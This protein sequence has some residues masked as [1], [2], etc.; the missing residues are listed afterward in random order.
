M[1]GGVDSSVSAYLLKKQGYEV[2]ALF[3]SDNPTL[4]TAQKQSYSSLFLQIKKESPRGG[5]IA[6]EVLSKLFQQVVGEDVAKSVNPLKTVISP[7]RE[8]AL[9]NVLLKLSLLS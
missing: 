5:D 2:E 4:T 7:R 8:K 3:M 6:Q 1:S 9:S